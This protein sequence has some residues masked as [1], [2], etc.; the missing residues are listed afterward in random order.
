V[1]AP[2]NGTVQV[3]VQDKVDVARINQLLV[4]QG[5]RVYYLN[6]DQHNLE[7]LFFSL[8]TPS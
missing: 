4:E 8:T 5:M 2:V 6:A 3:Q 7:D 1:S